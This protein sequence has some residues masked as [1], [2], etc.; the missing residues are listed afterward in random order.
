MCPLSRPPASSP[1]LTSSRGARQVQNKYKELD[2]QIDDHAGGDDCDA[3]F[4]IHNNVTAWEG[5]QD[6]NVVQYNY[7]ASL[8]VAEKPSPSMPTL[9]LNC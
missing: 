1:L 3:P 7:T 6:A 2:D 9:K 8:S 5:V 4:A